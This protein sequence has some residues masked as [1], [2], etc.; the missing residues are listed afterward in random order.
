MMLCYRLLLCFVGIYCL[1]DKRFY[2]SELGGFKMVNIVIRDLDIS[3]ELDKKAMRE[4]VGGRRTGN[5]FQSSAW[6]TKKNTWL[7]QANKPIWPAR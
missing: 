1:C 4:L 6:K 7:K 3:K 5:G 2:F